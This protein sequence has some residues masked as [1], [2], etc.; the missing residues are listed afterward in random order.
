M[1]DCFFIIFRLKHVPPEYGHKKSCPVCLKCF[2]T[3]GGIEFH[4]RS[5]HLNKPGG[6]CGICDK[7]FKNPKA[8][9]FHMIAHDEVHPY[10]CDIC[11]QM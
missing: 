9:K 5:I 8:F 6:L 7:G 2:K 3:L 4:Y 10:I 1:G 11:K